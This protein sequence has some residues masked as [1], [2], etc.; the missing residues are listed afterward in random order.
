ME[1]GVEPTRMSVAGFGEYRPVA[2]NDSAEGRNRNRRVVVV[3]MA[4]EDTKVTASATSA[5][6]VDTAASMA[7]GGETPGEYGRDTG[8]CTRLGISGGVAMSA[9]A[10]KSDGE[11]ARWVCFGLGTQEY[12]LPVL[13]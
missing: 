1:T 3:V 2:D 10:R 8:R 9:L 12:V 13:P 4:S 11:F 6:T 7:I 5:A